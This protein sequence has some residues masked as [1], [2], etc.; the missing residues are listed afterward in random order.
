MWMATCG[1]A[2]PPAAHAPSDTETHKRRRGPSAL[3]SLVRAH[4]LLAEWRRVM[5]GPE[6]P[7]IWHEGALTW[8]LFAGA[9]FGVCKATVTPADIGGLTEGVRAVPVLVNGKTINC[10]S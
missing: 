3:D 2:P 6:T 4:A 7:P 1:R 9:D 8:R 5:T 10:H